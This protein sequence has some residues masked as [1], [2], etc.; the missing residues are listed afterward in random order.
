MGLDGTE[1]RR[2]LKTLNTPRMLVFWPGPYW[3]RRLSL[4]EFSSMTLTGISL[5]LNVFMNLDIGLEQ[6]AFHI[7]TAVRS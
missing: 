3:V 1:A 4:S 7:C 5:A 6:G 2:A